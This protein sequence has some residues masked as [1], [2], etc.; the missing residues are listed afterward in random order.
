MKKED[1]KTLEEIFDADQ[2]AIKNYKD[3]KI[4]LEEWVAL[5]NKNTDYIKGLIKAG[6][7]PF[8]TKSSEKAYNAAFVAVQHSNDRQL[9]LDTVKLLEGA[10]TDDVRKSHLAYLMDRL[11]IMDNKPQLYGTQFK[12]DSDGRIVF[13]EIEQE[14]DLDKRREELGLGSFEEYKKMCGCNLC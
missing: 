5:V 4:S 6:Q 10:S 3:K 11:R 2:E 8:I 12:K 14:E 7:F 9:M 13:F 1:I